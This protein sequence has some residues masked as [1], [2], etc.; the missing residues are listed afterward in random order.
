MECVVFK[1]AEIARSLM[2]NLVLVFTCLGA[3]LLLK[4]LHR[5]P[6][7]ASRTLNAFVINV[8]LPALVLTQ[9]TPFLLEREL[10]LTLLVPVSMAWLNFALAF[11]LIPRIGKIFE[12]PRQTIGALVLTVGLANTSFVGFPLLEALMGPT[13]LGI[14]VLVDQPGTFLTLATWGIVTAMTYAGKA[15][16]T[17]REVAQK[18]FSFPPLLALILAF[19]MAAL[20]ISFP[21]MAL[22]V[23]AR[24]ASTLVPLALVAVGL[25][26]HVSRDVFTRRWKP[27][28]V[29]LTLKLA[30]FPALMAIGYFT[31][32]GREDFAA[33]VIVL[34]SAMAS[35]ITA[36]VVAVEMGLDEELANLMVGIGIPLSLLTVPAWH[37]F[38]G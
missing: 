28:A 38:L 24:L 20:N 16:T 1:L 10:N 30:V 13:A 22:E 5:F 27:L 25:Q 23:L 8:S 3:G 12:W 4:R 6:E 21:T 33:R 26:L 2:G 29:G 19:G 11:F 36:A 18:V 14:G 35:M 34:E 9:L 15:K 31:L 17:P 32:L 37:A 7:G